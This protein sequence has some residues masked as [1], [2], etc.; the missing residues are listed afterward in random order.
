MSVSRIIVGLAMA[1]LPACSV[2]DID[3]LTEDIRRLPEADQGVISSNRTNDRLIDVVSKKEAEEDVVGRVTCDEWR[4]IDPHGTIY[5]R[6]NPTITKSFILRLLNDNPS[7][8]LD[9]V[10]AEIIRRLKPSSPPGTGCTRV[11]DMLDGWSKAELQADLADASDSADDAEDSAFWLPTLTI[12]DLTS[13]PV[14]MGV[15]GVALVGGGLVLIVGSP[16][17]ALCALSPAV[18]CPGSPAYPPGST[19]QP[20]DEGDR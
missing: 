17:P 11:V 7:W 2:P 16:L 5:A 14:L 9:D 4:D 19:S 8:G 6:R 15:I 12:E 20:G 1:I 10:F 13:R 3:G 18:G